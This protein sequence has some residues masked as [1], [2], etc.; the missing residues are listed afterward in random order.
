MRACSRP[1]VQD[2]RPDT[3]IHLAALVS[4]AKK[5]ETRRRITSSIPRAATHRR[6]ATTQK[7]SRVV[8]ASSAAAYGANKNLPLHEATTTAPLRKR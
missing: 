1:P 7:I 3:I 8:L 6:R 2:F 5:L 4:V